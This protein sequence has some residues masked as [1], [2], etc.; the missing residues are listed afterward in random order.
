MQSGRVVHLLTSSYYSLVFRFVILCSC[1]N[2]INRWSKG[3]VPKSGAPGI[4]TAISM[5]IY[6]LPVSKPQIRRLYFRNLSTTDIVV[7]L[8]STKPKVLELARN[9]LRLE[10][11]SYLFIEAKFLYTNLG[12]F[13]Y[14]PPK[15]IGY[16]MPVYSHTLPIIGK[17]LNTEGMET[18]R[19][20]AFE[21]QVLFSSTVFSARDIIIDLPGTACLVES[22]SRPVPSSN[23]DSPVDEADAG[24]QKSTPP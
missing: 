3:P 11:Q 23:G 20:L 4:W 2:S 14:I 8:I 6:V 1:T 21:M 18:S 5:S 9:R 22:V 17:W 13:D 16:A 19:Q 24:S 10:P 12:A 15:L 7:K